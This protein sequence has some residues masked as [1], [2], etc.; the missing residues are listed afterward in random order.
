MKRP[1]KWSGCY[2]DSWRGVITPAAFAHPAKFAKALV[3]KVLDYLLKQN[4]IEPGAVVGDPF[5]GVGTGGIIA[6]YRGFRWIGNELE[7]K[8][9]RLARGHDCPGLS[10]Q[11]WVRWYGRFGRNP[12]LCP[13]CIATAHKVDVH[14]FT[15]C[16][17]IFLDGVLKRKWVVW[18]PVPSIEPHYFQGNFDL[19]RS[20]WETLGVPAPIMNQGDSR[21]FDQIVDAILSSPPYVSGGHHTDVM[22]AGNANGRG[23]RTKDYL[24]AV[25]ASPPYSGSLDDGGPEKAHPDGY[26]RSNNWTGYGKTDGQIAKLKEGKLDAVMTSPPFL[27]A[28]SETTSSCGGISK[29]GYEGSEPARPSHKVIGER[30]Y[31][32]GSGDHRMEGNIETLKG[33][34]LESVISEGQFPI[35][36][37]AVVAS[38]PYETVAAGAGGLNTKP[39]KKAGQQSGRK[40]GGSQGN[41]QRY[42]GAE[43]QIARAAKGPV[44]VVLT[45]PPYG[46]SVNSKGHGIDFSKCA[47]DYEGRVNHED[48]IEK[49]DTSHHGRNYGGTPGQ[50]GS[51]VVPS[52][53]GAVVSSPPWENNVE[54]GFRGSKFKTAAAGLKAKRGKG[55]SDAAR[56]AQMERDEHKTYGEAPGQIG[57]LKKQTYWEAMDQVYRACFRCLRDGGV[58]AIVVKDF[59]KN[60]KRCCLCDDTMRLLEHIGF[61]PVIRIHAMLVEEQVAG[62]LFEGTTTT[63]KER[64]SFFRRLHESKLKPGDKRRIDFEE[65]LIVRKPVAVPE[66]D[67]EDLGCLSSAP[68]ERSISLRCDRCRVKWA[69]CQDAQA[70]PRCGDGT[71]WRDYM[72]MGDLF[73][74]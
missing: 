42:G 9:V 2:D 48:R 3:E 73:I 67:Y 4:L 58:M 52:E 21:A 7:S 22:A 53:L 47:P 44:D 69:G 66:P 25:V 8:F 72:K 68:P 11:E 56:A 64:K 12:D 37:D 59:V 40:G 19:H 49:H 15:R 45:S 24:G 63:R 29:K 14:G 23:Q 17:E 13:S 54:G 27:G 46:D 34:E 74:Q 55:A 35:K 1:L 32:A 16:N 65:V 20:R 6:A 31:Q 28:R 36:L 62:D 71:S 39:A 26:S 70:C 10:R 18:Q 51:L 30:T 43:G 33:G 5:G 57:K 61:E 50:I 60:K 38:P 41:D